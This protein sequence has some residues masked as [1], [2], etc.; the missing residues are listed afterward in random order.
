MAGD[1]PAYRFRVNSTEVELSFSASDQNDHGYA[2]LQAADFVVVDKEIV[3]RNFQSFARSD[4]TKLDLGIL[5][6]ASESVTS[7]FRQEVADTIDLVSRT[8]GIPEDHLSVFSFRGASPEV[9]CSGNCRATHV[10]ERLPSRQAGGLTPL[11]DALVFA[12]DFL[13]QHG[14]PH[15]ERALILFSDG[16]DT[17]SRNSLAGAIDS[18]RAAQI[19][20][21]G[22]DL[23][24]DVLS[25]G[26]GV[27][28]SLA[29]STGGRYLMGRAG[30]ARALDLILEDFRASYTVSYRLPSNATGFHMVRVLPT[31]NLNLH[32][33][34]R[35]G[36]YYPDHR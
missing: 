30:P 16:N 34:S 10:A 5:I 36:Y 13:A 6:D 20:L 11:F 8:N 27:L 24:P 12:T 21:Y 29:E 7:R 28:R 1:Q 31:H 15:A 18:A 26:T 9:L 35:S 23:N 19:Q 4:W 22:I 25:H 17:I 2:T 3:V 14:D 32:F 33:R